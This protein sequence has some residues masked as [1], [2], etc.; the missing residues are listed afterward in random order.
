MKLF[1][2][3]WGWGGCKLGQGRN[4]ECKLLVSKGSGDLTAQL[5]LDISPSLLNPNQRPGLGVLS[6]PFYRCSQPSNRAE[7]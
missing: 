2:T 7:Q 1:V 5:L 4:E 3:S 6:F